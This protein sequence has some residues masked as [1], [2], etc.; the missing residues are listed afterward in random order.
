M[1]ESDPFELTE[2]EARGLAAIITALDE[3]GVNFGS[4]AISVIFDETQDLIISIRG[5]RKA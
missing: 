1:T 4:I 2:E 5:V 3:K